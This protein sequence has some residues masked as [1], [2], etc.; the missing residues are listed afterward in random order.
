MFWAL[1][2]YSLMRRWGQIMWLYTPSL[3]AVLPA[4]WQISNCNVVRT[5]TARPAMS[6][7]QIDLTSRWLLH[8]LAYFHWK[9]LEVQ[10]VVVYRKNILY[11]KHFRGTGR[12]YVF[13]ITFQGPWHLELVLCQVSL[14]WTECRHARWKHYSIYTFAQG[15]QP[16]PA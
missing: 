10:N 15:T 2:V 12:R 16:L 4:P 8:I 1:L 3:K 9:A 7:N 6:W 13:Q 11:D 5:I 14:T